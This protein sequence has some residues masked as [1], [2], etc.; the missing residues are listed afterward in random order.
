VWGGTATRTARPHTPVR[1]YLEAR[2][3]VQARANLTKA[4]IIL[5]TAAS[6]MVYSLSQKALR[7]GR[8][9]LAKFHC[10]GILVHR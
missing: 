5:Y 3:G 8:V 9:R 7:I 2:P 6:K 10:G 1:V 4:S